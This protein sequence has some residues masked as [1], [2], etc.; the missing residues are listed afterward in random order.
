MKDLFSAQASQYARFRPHYPEELYT[1]LLAQVPGRE[2]LWDCAT[3]S[4]QA[5][6]RLAKDFQQVEAS[7]MS[8][9]QIA[10]ATAAPNI[11]Y[12]LSPA[13]KT[14]FPDHHFDLVTVA[15]ALHWFNFEAFFAEVKRVTKPGGYFA[16]WTYDICEAPAAIQPL[17]NDFYYNEIHPWFDPE[18]A[19]IDKRYGNIPFP[20]EM[21]KTPIFHEVVNWDKAHVAGFLDSWSAVQ[22]Y[23]KANDGRSPVPGFMEKLDLVWPD[24]VEK[25][26]FS[27]PLTL[28]LGRV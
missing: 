19:H 6:V 11:N 4:G 17:I 22:H 12:S 24:E 26:E 14:P 20:F 15:Q 1:W 18:R 5:A 2:T 23:I 25:Q 28:K 10:N 16:A 8:P 13:E 9:S 3:G 7:D 21:V 27:F